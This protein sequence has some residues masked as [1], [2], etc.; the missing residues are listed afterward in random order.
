MHQHLAVV[1]L[2]DEVVQHLLSDFEVGDDAILHGLDGHDVARCAAKHFLGLFTNS[3]DF[4]GVLIQGHNR[5][6]VYH[7]AFA[8]RV[9]QR[10]GGA[11]VDGEVAGEDAEQRPQVRHA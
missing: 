8:A 3:L 5:R 4:V 1:R 10:I 11:Q 9:H 6:F 2:L 7:N